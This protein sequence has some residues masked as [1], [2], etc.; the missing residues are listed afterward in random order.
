[1][2]KRLPRFT[3]LIGWPVIAALVLSACG[4]GAATT[5]APQPTAAPT[6]APQGPIKIAIMGPFTGPAASI[7]VEQL[8]F[9][10]LAVADFNKAMG[11]NIELLEED[12]QL[13]PAIATT[14][15]QKLVADQALYAV[16]GPSGSQ[17]VEAS[18]TLFEE[19]KLAHVS[20]SATR[21]SL[22]QSGYKTFFRVVPNDSVQGPTDARF[23]ADT[24]KAK[25]VFIID[26]Q[27][28]YS[29]SL[30][31][32]VAQELSGMD[33]TTARE[34]VT[35]EDTDFSA[36][37]TK[38]KAA[39][40]E[41][42]FFPGQIASQGAQLW[43]QMREQGV[44]ATLMGGDGFNSPDLIADGANEGSFVSNF[45]PDINGVP[46][47]ADVIKA[48][49]EQYGDFGSFGP[50]TYVAAQV[51]LEA[52][53]NAMKA[54][55]L[56]REAVLAEVAK[57]KIAKSLL[58]TPME[59]DANGDVKG[60]QFYVFQAQSGQFT[61]VTQTTELTGPQK[62]VKIAIMGPFTGPAASIGV[63]QLNFARL[64]VALH[65]LAGGVPIQLI[66]EDTQLD[67]AI[68]TTA[69]QKLAA[70]P[71]I[72]A[73]I[74]PSGSQEVQASAAILGDAGVVH[75]SPSATRPT[76]TAEGDQREAAKTFF[77]VVPND[78]VQ[79]PTDAN[80]ILNVLQ[81]TSAFIIDDQSSY[82][83]SLSDIVEEVVKDAG[84]TVAR[85][86]VTQDDTDFS[87]LVTKI[88]AA[89][90]DVVFFPGQIASQGAQLWSQMREQGVQATLVGGDGFNSPDLVANGANEGSYV[91]NF[92]PDIT[93]IAEAAEV[94]KAYKDQYGDFGAFGPP[95][96]VA[97]QVLIEAIARAA[98]SGN[99]TREGVLAEVAKTNI[100]K[101]ILGSPVGFDANGDV[102]G[103]QFFVF[104]VEGGKF[105]TF[106]P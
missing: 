39:N 82:S 84:I 42:V 27:S 86:S 88:K 62:A 63:E 40:A 11:T 10:R 69:A 24:L 74:G 2:F 16:I 33:V 60:A 66:E 78:S 64:A 76:L 73:I 5:A 44:T 23:I 22:T 19:A 55:A 52:V 13:D 51:V 65:N 100:A 38:I 87:A 47:A 26:D 31:E 75:V 59:F 50:P 94:A 9:A 35:Q 53:S 72:L 101:S 57:V 54:G 41:V 81:A 1:M 34:S 83:A 49:Q 89:K 99:L 20:P 80:L 12:T 21:P 77:R 7:G 105:V 4:G 96:Y 8:N 95:T 14:V 67:P 103:A 29:A 71:D 32:G 15:A 91:T 93:S 25:S 28:S 58:G 36:L 85:E 90:A 17:E 45:A 48:Y 106:T 70:D 102:Q 79:G 56:T 18:A 104:K 46:E 3:P 43:K 30:A 98:Q 92:A 61:L 37:V 6:E 68:A 97:A